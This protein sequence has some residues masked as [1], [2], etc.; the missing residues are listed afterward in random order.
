MNE[1][2]KHGDHEQSDHGKW[3]QG[4]DGKK[5]AEEAQK[6]AD[7]ALLVARVGP[8][9]AMRRGGA[10]D[11][12]PMFKGKAT[13]RSVYAEQQADGSWQYDDDRVAEHEKYYDAQLSKATPVDSP[14]VV[15]LG[16]GPGSGK[17][18]VR[19]GLQVGDN[20]VLSNADEAKGVLPEYNMGLK[21]HDRGIAAFVHE[22]SSM[23]GKELNRR[24]IAESMN[25]VIDGTGDGIDK[26]VDKVAAVRAASP[27]AQVHGDYV[28]LPTDEAWTR[29]VDRASRIGSDSYGRHVPEEILRGT[30]ASVSES[31]PTFLSGKT[32]A[33]LFDELRLWDNNV[34]RGSRPV[35]IL[36]QK[37]GKTVVYDERAYFDFLG[38]S[39]KY[40]AA[41]TGW[42]LGPNGV[43]IKIEVSKGRIV[44]DLTKSAE[45][46]KMV[47][48][49]DLGQM[50]IAILYDNTWEEFAASFPALDTAEHKASWG[51]L[52]RD[53][54]GMDGS[55]IV[56]SVPASSEGV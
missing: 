10:P 15:F 11:P 24:A 17:S 44:Y 38:K 26:M 35:L 21:K 51:R 30:H 3:A 32:G 14:V 31:F 2:V 7:E 43:P 49:D 54:K 46:D 42:F 28:T 19:N 41:D 56:P 6:K 23:M 36:E 8:F 33:P 16:G 25:L 48:S 55:E 53:V 12:D 18:T 52:A 37:G 34:P 50:L 40:K 45:D 22:E 39:D 29:S 9:N 20:H 27:K 1:V 5:K 47:D 13:T 4:A